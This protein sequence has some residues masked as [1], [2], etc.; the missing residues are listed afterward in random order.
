MY[1]PPDSV[2]WKKHAKEHMECFQKLTGAVSVK[3]CAIFPLPKA[4]H[5]K[6]SPRE[7]QWHTK[8]GDADNV[9]KACLDAANEILFDDDCQVARLVVEKIIA[10]QGDEPRVIMR[11]EE[12]EPLESEGITCL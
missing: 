7:A 9:A 8:R 3:I 6:H 10:A 5:R 1:D 11:L 12:L 2:K 4:E